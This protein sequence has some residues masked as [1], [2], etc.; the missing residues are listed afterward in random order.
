MKFE[1][2]VEKDLKFVQSLFELISDNISGLAWENEK[3]PNQIIFTGPLGKE[4]LDLIQEKEWDFNKFNLESTGGIHSTLTFKYNAPLTQT[5]GK[6]NTLFEGGTLHNKEING[7][8]GPETA[9]KILSTYSSP[10][11]TIERTVRPEK[12]IVLI[13]S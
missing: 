9:Q 4:L 7:I 5:E 1:V 11:F 8:P 6:L 10:G 2:P 12:R 3:L 13:R